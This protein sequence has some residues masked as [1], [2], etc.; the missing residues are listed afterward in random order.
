MQV[1]P[2]I[3]LDNAALAS[4]YAIA[5]SGFIIGATHV[6]CFFRDREIRAREYQQSLMIY[7]LSIS[8]VYCVPLT[9]SVAGHGWSRWFEIFAGLA[10]IIQ[11]IASVR[12]GLWIHLVA[13]WLKRDG[14][15]NH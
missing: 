10:S 11:A 9:C 2:L 12:Y 15:D 3:T 13:R 7:A 6:W 5:F 14:N 8:L 4:R 1:P